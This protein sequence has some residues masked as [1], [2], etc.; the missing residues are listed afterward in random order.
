MPIVTKFILAIIGSIL[1]SLSCT[2]YAKGR[3]SIEFLEVTGPYGGGT[4][5]LLELDSKYILIDTGHA[6]YSSLVISKIKE[7][8]DV[9][10]RVVVTHPHKDHYGG[11]V[12]ISKA[13]KI[14]NLHIH[15]VP[16]A[17]KDFSFIPS[18]WQSAVKAVEATGTKVIKESI[19]NTYKYNEAK[20]STVY[21]N[22]GSGSTVNDYSIVQTLTVFGTTM[23][24]TGDLDA[25][26]GEE[27]LLYVKEHDILQN[28]HHGVTTQ[29]DIEF[30]RKVNPTVLVTSGQKDLVGP[31]RAEL[32]W[33]FVKESSVSH[34]NVATEGAIKIDFD[35]E[36]F[37]IGSKLYPTNYVPQ[38]PSLASILFLLL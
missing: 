26:S 30:F 19:G 18:E 10:H 7:L 8:T 37:T 17:R 34:Y 12:D 31:P 25:L 4:S 9:L 3:Y 16:S 38:V 36:G 28:P 6:A 27:F 29:P 35:E 23:L 14:E 2:S 22:L 20:L 1:V 15:P 32:T 5:A 11:L 13:V 24:L 33:K 21:L